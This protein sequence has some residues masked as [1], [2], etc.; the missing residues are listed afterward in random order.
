M[1]AQANPLEQA[2]WH[3]AVSQRV[4]SPAARPPSARTPRSAPSASQSTAD[5]MAEAL[6]SSEHEVLRDQPVV[7]TLHVYH[8]KA[9]RSP[10]DHDLER[11]GIL[12]LHGVL[13][14]FTT[15]VDHPVPFSLPASLLATLFAP[16]TVGRAKD[17]QPKDSNGLADPFVRIMFDAITIADTAIKARTLHPVWEE[18]F[19]IHWYAPFEPS[20]LILVLLDQDH[21]AQDFMG[22]LYLPLAAEAKARYSDWFSLGRNAS[23][24]RAYCQA[25]NLNVPVLHDPAR[26]AER[27]R[28]YRSRMALAL[29]DRLDSSSDSAESPPGSPM[30]QPAPVS[31]TSSPTPSASFP[32]EPI[33]GSFPDETER[34]EMCL[35]T[36]A[37]SCGH[38]RAFGS[39]YITNYRLIVVAPAL[40]YDDDAGKSSVSSTPSILAD[41]AASA[42]RDS[43]SV[44]TP[45]VKTFSMSIPHGLLAAAIVDAVSRTHYAAQPTDDHLKLP[46]RSQIQDSLRAVTSPRR[47]MHTLRSNAA[48]TKGKS[49]PET[50]D[51][52]VA[53]SGIDDDANSETSVVSENDRKPT[54]RQE[55]Q[56]QSTTVVVT[57]TCRDARTVR[58]AFPGATGSAYVQS[59]P[60]M[61]HAIDAWS[62]LGMAQTLAAR[63]EHLIANCTSHRAADMYGGGGRPEDWSRYDPM[64]EMRRQGLVF[65]EDV[66]SGSLS[67]WMKSD[68]N[69]DYEL[70]PTYPPILFLPRMV[71]ESVIRGSAAFR[72]KQRLPVLTWYSDRGGRRRSIVRDQIAVFDARSMIAAGGNQ[73]MGKGSENSAFYVGAQ[74]FFM[75]IGNIHTMRASHDKLLELCIGVSD[76][77]WYS[78]LE[79]T[80]WLSHIKAVLSAARAIARKVENLAITAL[81]HCSD[82]WDRTSQL[83]SLA[84]I[85]LDPYFRTIDG[86]I[87]VIEKD[88]LAFGHKFDERHGG[89]DSVTERSPIF[90]Q[91]L[92]CLYQMTVQHPTAFEYNS[93]L[94][95]FLADYSRAGWFG[96]FQCNSHRERRARRLSQTTT[97]IWSAVEADRP[98]FT[99]S[100]YAPG[101]SDVIMPTCSL[102]RIELWSDYFLRYD[103]SVEANINDDEDEEDVRA[104]RRI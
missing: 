43:P 76:V 96:N 97:S 68:L 32:S 1:D 51:P 44:P 60:F 41:L 31:S 67:A 100:Q 92:D 29:R 74:V 24:L 66:F 3:A 46:A 69:R 21:I 20:Y 83:V 79:N 47:L 39:L 84:Q 88:W 85:M 33:I 40:C 90:L 65:E 55:R 82:G 25:N 22:E 6:A 42:G 12:H 26:E 35:K 93:R 34:P 59:Q 14:V 9:H 102:K 89:A 28:T 63:I 13:H 30:A 27:K 64:A 77:Q 54:K 71:S 87:V 62:T 53:A 95:V 72:S 56:A 17:L 2:S 86:L 10:P 8:G 16:F 58:I 7:K 11:N 4:M 45:N 101:G 5:A 23:E 57:I 73:I 52:E 70:C 94:L 81:V 103:A 15:N 98:R 48:N 61:L 50:H 80:G 49:K 75:E 38:T 37:I 104:Y 99:S 78:Q 18:D 19:E 91:F 36:V